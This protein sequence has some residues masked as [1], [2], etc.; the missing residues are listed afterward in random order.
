[1]VVVLLLNLTTTITVFSYP[2]LK[3]IL[4]NTYRSILAKQSDEIQDDLEKFK[5]IIPFPLI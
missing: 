1:M 4:L 2:L 3:N 5:Q